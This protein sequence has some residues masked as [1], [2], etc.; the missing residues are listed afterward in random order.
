MNSRYAVLAFALAVA[1]L[2]PSAT[3]F[4]VSVHYAADEAL[5]H[6]VLGEM[7]IEYEV[8]AD[9]NGDPVWIFIHSGIFITIVSY[10]ETT[11]DRYASL[12][13]YAGWAAH[14]SVSL[15]EINDWNSRSRF[16]RAYVDETGDPVVE[17][18]LL[19]TGGVTAQTLKEYIEIFVAAV[20]DLGVALRL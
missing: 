5:L 15:F 13:F 12:L 10:D 11:P 8:A 6:Q 9:E 3:A 19:L 2:G 17:L 16:G 4:A 18:D 14:S 1:L 7:D 20:S